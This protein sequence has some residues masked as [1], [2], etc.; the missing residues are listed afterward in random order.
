MKES[1]TYHFTVEGETEDIYFS[2]L[3]GIINTQT[4][5]KYNVKIVHKICKN[6]VKYSKGLTNISKINVTH[7]FDIE[8]QDNIHV[9]QVRQTL[10]RMREAEK[11]GKDIKYHLGYTNFT[12][13]LWIILHKSECN[14][15]LIHRDKYLEPLNKA[16]NENFENLAQYKHEKELKRILNKLDINDVRDAIKRAKYIMSNYENNRLSSEKY[17]GFCYCKDNP[18]LSICESVEKI[19][20]D[21]GLL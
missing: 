9:Q 12:F 18:S 3:Q 10:D 14:G 7:V 8:S 1:L 16:Y 13:E 6:P 19:L 4:N 11:T 21:I 5:R 17:K 20:K 15:P 2:W